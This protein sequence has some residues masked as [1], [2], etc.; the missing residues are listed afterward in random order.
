M[1]TLICLSITILLLSSC[2]KEPTATDIIEVNGHEVYVTHADQI[3]DT[4][5]IM[6]SDMLEYCEVI[7]WKQKKK[8]LSP[9]PIKLLYQII[10]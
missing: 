2:G 1:R 5:D 9:G 8:H 6:L 10:I 4:V 3:T 7:P